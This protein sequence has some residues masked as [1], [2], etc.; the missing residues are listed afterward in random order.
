MSR[1]NGRDSRGGIDEI[2]AIRSTG[3]CVCVW[4]GIFFSCSASS[5]PKKKQ[6]ENQQVKINGW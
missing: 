2:L 3:L 6:Q 1:C 5:W 4:G